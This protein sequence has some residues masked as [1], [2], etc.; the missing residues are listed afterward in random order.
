MRCRTAPFYCPNLTL[1]SIHQA[2]KKASPFFLVQRFLFVCVSLKGM[3]LKHF[4]LKFSF[5]NFRASSQTV[6]SDDNSR[7]PQRELTT[8]DVS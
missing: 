8:T 2:E 1:L 7:Y 5:S 3:I 4:G 6:N